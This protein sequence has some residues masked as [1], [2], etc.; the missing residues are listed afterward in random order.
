MA[1]R[2][3]TRDVRR[4]ANSRCSVLL[5]RICTEKQ[6]SRK[7]CTKLLT[8]QYELAKIQEAKEIPT[9]K[10]RDAAIMPTKK[11]FPPRTWIVVLGTVP[12]F[13]FSMTWILGKT[14]WEAVDADDPRRVC[15]TVQAHAK[16]SGKRNGR[17][18]PADVAEEA[19]RYR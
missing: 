18:A 2:P 9:V 19:V 17:G 5:A 10:V 7:P 4:R 16:A 15:A 1:V 8:Q 13:T 12:G 6:K 3:K 14:C 11:S